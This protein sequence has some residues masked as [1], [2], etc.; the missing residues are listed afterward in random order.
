MGSIS[1]PSLIIDLANAVS[2]AAKNLDTQ[3]QSQGFPQPSFE[4][5]GPTYV[6]PK[7][8]PKAA[9]EARVAT[10]EAAL[11][12]FNLVSGPS[13]LLPNMT[14]SVCSHASILVDF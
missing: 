5:D 10:A 8:A 2:S 3:L 12:L 14:A 7:D 11:K 9:H 6:V 1:S 13:E 4:A